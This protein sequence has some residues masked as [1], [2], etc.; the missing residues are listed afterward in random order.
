MKV[1]Y[2]SR[3]NKINALISMAITLGIF[4]YVVY[5]F[6]QLAGDFTGKSEEVFF[7]ADRKSVV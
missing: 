6:F 4:V 2:V 3:K 1:F 5:L 7:M